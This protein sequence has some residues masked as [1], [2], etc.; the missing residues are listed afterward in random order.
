MRRDH[1]AL[2]FRK[3]GEPRLH[4]GLKGDLLDKSWVG[5]V[6]DKQGLDVLFADLPDERRDAFAIADAL[7]AATAS[8]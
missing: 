3:S 1:L 5:Y 8:Q 6:L 7:E 2:C 4:I